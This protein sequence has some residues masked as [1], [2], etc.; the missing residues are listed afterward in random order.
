MTLDRHGLE[1]LVLPG[2]HSERDGMRAAQ[3][4][5]LSSGITAVMAFNDRCAVGV[6][7]VLDKARVRVPKQM[8]VTGFD[9]SLVA[10]L[11]RMNLTTISQAPVEQA[12]LA[13]AA[14]IE[15]LDGPRTERVEQ[16]LRPHLVIRG[17]TAKAP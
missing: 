13:V 1:P 4:L 5:D 12:R 14:A 6:L 3:A 2:G 16:I 15:R 10:Q 17:S 8:S 9:D 11:R 7:D